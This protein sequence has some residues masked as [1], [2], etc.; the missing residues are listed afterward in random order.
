MRGKD[1][2]HFVCLNPESGRSNPSMGC[3]AVEDTLKDLLSRVP[4]A[5]TAALDAL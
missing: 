2:Q 4:A 1:Q 3:A 5:S